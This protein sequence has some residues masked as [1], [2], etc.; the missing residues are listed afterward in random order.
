MQDFVKGEGTPVNLPFGGGTCFDEMIDTPDT[1]MGNIVNETNKEEGASQYHQSPYITRY[2]RLE[3]TIWAPAGNRVQ[4]A[5]GNYT[6]LVRE[7]LY[8]KPPD[9]NPPQQAR[10]WFPPG[11]LMSADGK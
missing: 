5:P 1:C 6:T 8:L 2:G 9:Q 11:L 3:I 7:S 4:L 10:K